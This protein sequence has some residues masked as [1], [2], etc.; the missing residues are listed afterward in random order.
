[1]LRAAALVLALLGLA[2][3]QPDQPPRLPPVG[4]ASTTQ[5][6]DACLASGGVYTGE[7]GSKGRVCIHYT[8]DAGKRCTSSNQCE[9]ACLARSQSCAPIRPLLGC[10]DIL[11]DNGIPMTQCIN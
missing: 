7:E 11:T 6:K 9:S 4:T 1:M 10:Q 8:K 3:C 2:A 5:V